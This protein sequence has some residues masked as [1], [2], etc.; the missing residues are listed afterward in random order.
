VRAALVHEE[1]KAEEAKKNNNQESKQEMERLK[2]QA[3]PKFRDK[4]FSIK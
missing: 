1:R 4:A 3:A 2:K